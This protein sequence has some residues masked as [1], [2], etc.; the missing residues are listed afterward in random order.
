MFGTLPYF[1]LMYESSSHCQDPTALRCDKMQFTTVSAKKEGQYFLATS[2]KFAGIRVSPPSVDGRLVP[3]ELKAGEQAYNFPNRT[4]PHERLYSSVQYTV[5]GSDL[6][7]DSMV[8]I[9]GFTYA[10]GDSAKNPEKATRYIYDIPET[11]IGVGQSP[12]VNMVNYP[13]EPAAAAGVTA[14]SPLSA[15]VFFDRY[16][17]VNYQPLAALEQAIFYRRQFETTGLCGPDFVYGRSPATSKTY[18][19]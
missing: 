1:G 12:A 11:L 18:N 14:T 13:F 2:G 15:Q 16:G 6:M 4:A 3:I 8:R 9:G 17:G 5:D 7:T 10:G 19:W